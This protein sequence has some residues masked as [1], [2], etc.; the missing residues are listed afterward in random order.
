MKWNILFILMLATTQATAQCEAILPFTEASM[1]DIHDVYQF[2]FLHKKPQNKLDT[3]VYQMMHPAM[4]IDSSYYDWNMLYPQVRNVVDRIK[5]V[6]LV[7][8]IGA[9]RSQ[10]AFVL[11]SL[12]YMMPFKVQDDMNPYTSFCYTLTQYG[13]AKALNMYYLNG[14]VDTN[15]PYPEFNNTVVLKSI[16]LRSAMFKDIRYCKPLEG[17]ARF[18]YEMSKVDPKPYDDAM[19]AIFAKYMNKHATMKSYFS[20]DSITMEVYQLPFFVDAIWDNCV[21]KVGAPDGVNQEQLG[22]IFKVDTPV[23]RFIERVYIINNSLEKGQ[24]LVDKVFQPNFVSRMRQKCEVYD[25]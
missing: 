7:N 18:Y 16:P 15:L 22:V 12:S 5:M 8:D 9:M 21:P 20:I 2:Q 19:E 3:M 6:K 4:V 13:G 17:D 10:E 23:T 1:K 14:A 24:V 25:K 11:L